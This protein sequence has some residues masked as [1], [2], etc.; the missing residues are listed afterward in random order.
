MFKYLAYISDLQCI[1]D[2]AIETRRSVSLF[3]G[4]GL[5]EPDVISL[6]L[7]VPHSCFCLLSVLL[8]L[9]VGEGEGVGICIEVRP[10]RGSVRE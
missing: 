6:C 10:V 2:N 9:T 1:N 8:I 5:T 7:V 4:R 3:L